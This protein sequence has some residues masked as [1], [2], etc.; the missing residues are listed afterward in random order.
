MQVP[1]SPSITKG[2]LLMNTMEVLTLIM[3]IFVILEFIDKRND[4]KK[5]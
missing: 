3:V 2:V 1:L 4:N 5:N